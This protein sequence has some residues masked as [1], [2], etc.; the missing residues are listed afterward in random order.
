MKKLIAVLAVSIASTAALTACG[1]SD[2][3]TKENLAS[4]MDQICTDFNPK[5]DQLGVRGIENDQVALEIEGTSEVRKQVIEAFKGVDAD[6][7]AQ[8]G[9]DR[10]IAASEAILPYDRQIVAAAKQDDTAGVNRAFKDFNAAYAERTAVAKEL[11]LKVCGST[12]ELKVEPTGTEPPA[13]LKAVEPKNGIEAA[14]AGHLKAI[15]SG[16]CKT[17]N[18]ARHTDAGELDE[19]A[20]KQ[21]ATVLGGAKVA[22][23]EQYGPVGQAEIV[24]RDG[25]H[26]PTYFVTDL[27]GTL[28]YG[29]DAIH[30]GGG[31][32]PAP[33]GNDAEATA[34][35]TVRAI[36]DSDAAAFNETLPGKS[37]AFWVDGEKFE[38]FGKGKFNREFI[39]DIRNSDAEPVQLGLNST[40]GFY[41]LEGSRYD[42]VISM[43]HVPGSGGHYRFSGY[44][45]I[46]KAE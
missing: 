16:D 19:A 2:Q 45:P 14:A 38:S 28:R 43:I 26:Y 33:E 46:P 42:W 27:D 11:G 36:R 34:E 22:G 40:W 23:T 9:L 29:G 13:D 32:R 15:G 39:E 35:D 41:F 10:Y 17:I 1:G 5:F 8:T 20:C 7:D 3:V 31:L 24:G 6:Q 18:A 12:P 4:T 44:Y 30:D 37:S 25:T 21:V